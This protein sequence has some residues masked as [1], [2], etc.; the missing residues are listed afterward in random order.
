MLKVIILNVI[1][2]LLLLPLLLI[3]AIDILIAIVNLL[4][5]FVLQIN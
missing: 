3:F 1:I 2:L 5:N 4:C